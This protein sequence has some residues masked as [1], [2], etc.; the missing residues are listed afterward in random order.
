MAEGIIAGKGP[1]AFDT[2][3]PIVSRCLRSFGG[4]DTLAAIPFGTG[5]KDLW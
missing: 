5:G 3:P 1:F 2:A 4:K